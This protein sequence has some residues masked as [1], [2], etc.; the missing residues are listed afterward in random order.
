MQVSSTAQAGLQ[1]LWRSPIH[2]ENVYEV[3][4]LEELEVEDLYYL[5]FKA[6]MMTQNVKPSEF[7]SEISESWNHTELEGST[8]TINPIPGPAQDTP[9]IPPCA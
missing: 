2:K 6:A 4:I 1:Q 9:T 5:L 8:G 3:L 7:S